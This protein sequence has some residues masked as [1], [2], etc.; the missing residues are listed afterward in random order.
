MAKQPKVPGKANRGGSRPR[1]LAFL[2]A[3]LFCVSLVFA[4]LD[5]VRERRQALAAG[6]AALRDLARVA[7]A[8]WL[9]DDARIHALL[10]RL[11]IE[12]RADGRWASTGSL[13]NAA[14]AAADPESARR[15][16]T[17]LRRAVEG[18]PEVR[19]IDLVVAGQEGLSS[20][21]VGPDLGLEH[22]TAEPQ[23]D[24]EDLSKA[25]WYSDEVQQAVEARGRRVA[26]GPLTIDSGEGAGR[27]GVRAAIAL[28]DG[29]ELVQ[30]ALVATI[31]LG[32]L[33][34]RLASLAAART[35]F[36]LVG[37]DGVRIGESAHP[38]TGK[39]E[40]LLTDPS[41]DASE[42]AI[43]ILAKAGLRSLIQ[44]APQAG[45]SP[46]QIAFW[47][48]CDAPPSLLAAALHSPWP[49]TLGALALLVAALVAWDRAAASVQSTAGGLANSQPPAR[50]REPS[51]AAE[52]ALAA[53]SLANEGRDGD[54]GE[55]STPI[56]RER[57]VLRDWL[58]DVR[59]CLEREAAT[60]GLTLD[61]RCE[62]SLPREIEQDPLWLGGLLVSLGREALD[63]TR[64]NRVA[65]EVTEESAAALRF[66]IDAGE[67]DL[68]AVP[69]MNVIAGRLG[70]ELDKRGPGRLAVV[71]PGA[72]V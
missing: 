54:V 8:L 49:L 21:R 57:F 2:S 59:G 39:L 34:T 24:P 56:R 47:L 5:L 45:Q 69:G 68:E 36:A 63:A 38:P 65:L 41:L 16:N 52:R 14:T 27:S 40:S 1:K 4:T 50:E 26:R 51:A 32:P 30:G 62:R 53:A 25:L 37:P 15:T 22:A 20:L 13:A 18:A 71:V 3:G 6:D 9:A 11:R 58:A 42:G 55:Q 72:L 7:D 64:A 60:R 43:P 29:D 66:E 19:S 28:H 23:A 33:G 48:E 17:L 35:R 61:L 46:S 44:A 12:L 70:A 67:T 10:A 31:D